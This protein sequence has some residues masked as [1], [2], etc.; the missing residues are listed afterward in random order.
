MNANLYN[1]LET[2]GAAILDDDNVRIFKYIGIWNNQLLDMKEGKIFDF[3]KPALF[4]EF[5]A[6]QVD[7][8][9]AGVQVF[10]PLFI[11]CHIIDDF[12][13]EGNGLIELN[14]RTFGLA[15]KLYKGFQLKRIIGDDYGTSPLNRT[16]LELDTDSDGNYHHITTFTTTWTDNSA[17]E[18]EGGYE[19]DPVLRASITSTRDFV[20]SSPSITATPTTLE[21][22]NVSVGES[23]ILT[24]T[25]QGTGLKKDLI[26]STSFGQYLIGFASN[27]STRIV[28]S[29]EEEEIIETTINVKFTPTST[30][31]KSAHLNYGVPNLNYE[32][33]L[34]GIGI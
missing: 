4:F 22:G 13:D 17:P 20:P 8:I 29:P 28:M 6:D 2:L 10:D 32:L 18:P 24:F 25:I 12:L 11:K 3:Q 31:V 14:T 27:Y 15:D 1:G 33:T 30:G 5:I 7:A 9:G 21:F 19:I 16:S 23:K 34:T 26:I